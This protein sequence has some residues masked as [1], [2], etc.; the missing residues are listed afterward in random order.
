MLLQWNFGKN[1]T[2]AREAFNLSAFSQ[3][4]KREKD[5]EQTV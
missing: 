5:E 2:E 4:Q 1:V 3:T